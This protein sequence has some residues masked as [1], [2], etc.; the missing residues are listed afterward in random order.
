MVT[1]CQDPATR[2]R[3][4][5]Q[6]LRD[7][8][9]ETGDV[10][11]FDRKCL[12]M[13]LYGGAICLCAKFLGQTPWDHNGVVVRVPS[14]APHAT[15]PEDEL[16]LLEAALSGVKLRPLV[17]RIV[18]SRGHEVALRQLQLARTPAFQQKAVEFA[19][20]SLDT[21]YED[22][23]ATFF[24]A[25]VAVPTRSARER[26]FAALMATKK[27][28]VR[29]D[30]ELA[31][32]DRM[33]PFERNALRA[34]RD[35]VHAHYL[36]LGEKL[37]ARERSVFENAVDEGDGSSRKMFCSQLVAGL[38]QHLGLL[39]PYP[40]TNSYLP[41]HFSATGGAA[42]L[43][44]QQGASFLPAV[45]LRRKLE[46]ETDKAATRVHE[47]TARGPRSASERAVIVHC[48]RRHPLF[49]TLSES[50][51]LATASHFRRH[52]LRKGEVVF[53]QGAPGDY[54]YIVE[55]GQCEVYV[56][57]QESNQ[58]QTALQ[59]ADANE[60]MKHPARAPP[61]VLRKRQTVALPEFKSSSR[62]VG[63][64]ERVQV[65]TNG[66]GQAFGESA[67]IY[68][69]PRRA[70]IQASG[71]DAD[72]EDD[73][74]VLWQLEKR[75]FR[76]IVARHPG[77]Q[78]SMEERRFLLQTLEE[79]PLFAELDERAQAVAV[80]KCFPLH[81]RAGSTI[82]RQGDP[83]DYFYLV[84]SGRCQVSRRKP[85]ATKVFIDRIIG[86]GASFGEAALL[87]NSR[88]GASVKALDDVKIWCMDRA[89]F[90]TITRSGST[91]LYKLFRKIGSSV[92]AGSNESFATEKDLRR[93]L[94]APQLTRQSANKSD[95]DEED[96][97]LMTN[98]VPLAS[99]E[100][101]DRAVKLALSL[102]L[103][104]S[105]GLVN[106]SQFAHFHIALSASNIDQLLSEAAFRVLKSIA[107][108]YAEKERRKPRSLTS[109]F[110]FDQEDPDQ[111]AIK[112]Q[113]LPRALHQWMASKDTAGKAWNEQEPSV[114]MT[115]GR[116][117]LYEQLFDL[118]AHHFGD[119]YITH[120]DLVRG[121]ASLELDDKECGREQSDDDPNVL[122]AKEEFRAF[123]AALKSDLSALRSIWR[124]AELQA[125]VGDD[126]D[127]VEHEPEP[128]FVSIFKSSWIAA[129]RENP[130]GSDWGY[131]Q[132]KVQDQYQCLTP[133][134]ING[135]QQVTSQATS[136]VAA[137]AAGALM[138]TL[139]APLERLKMLMQVS[140][141]KPRV[142]SRPV[143]TTAPPYTS[144]TRGLVNMVKL[145]GTRSL[146]SG[147][148]VH[149]IEMIPLVSMR[150]LVCHVY[151]Q[152]RERLFP[153]SFDL[154]R[155]QN[156]QVA[157]RV[158]N[159]TV[160]AL[161]ALTLHC[162]LYPLDVIRGRLTVQQYYN[163]NR[164]LNGLVECAR[165][166]RAK[167]GVRAF[168][169]GFVPSSLG[170][171]TYTGCNVALYESLRPLFMLDDTKS[172]HTG[173]GQPTIRGQI[174]CS[175]VAALASQC[176]AYPFD[177]I[178]RR[179]QLQSTS[180]HPELEFPPSKSAWQ[181][182]KLSA[183]I[184]G[185][186]VRTM[187]LLYRGMFVNAIKAFPCTIISFLSYEKLCELE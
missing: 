114:E 17:A 81:V 118:P 35:A 26:L 180:W 143:G 154:I 80:R 90:L 91:A 76:D 136:L 134:R 123:L 56:E 157:A 158:T 42:F 156:P 89:S 184:E 149:C 181:W 160:G 34:E 84:E 8:R 12:S 109:P 79:H 72:E 129:V 37:R 103:N 161:V 98:T 152:Q 106:F 25:G 155:V 50:D 49:H 10:V 69:T 18:R 128:S 172:T 48:L 124:A 187:R 138:R 54:F 101:Y 65:A 125:H 39:L 176:L 120:D 31:H 99:E 186:G 112:L 4:V 73:A 171:C 9:V 122:A 175:T 145:G 75:A 166:I 87:Y 131:V 88:R 83:G 45:S 58:T 66:P 159:L 60:T 102:L 173:L 55:R 14:L 22:D 44:L 167:E 7:L 183:P 1:T 146:W 92:V 51:L 132:P 21:P 121:I 147:N 23:W 148:L 108:S 5:R 144:L 33:P 97:K 63:K 36:A 16:F 100:A 11:L 162:V 111:A 59:G 110:L 95:G 178:T 165:F 41:K 127:K 68:D 20:T 13:G 27:E 19:L 40:S 119:Q 142:S 32:R 15:A 24:N 133:S 168:Y 61:L 52:A 77:T 135:R 96:E 126:A 113:D 82:L 151:Q 130:I 164:P 153:A 115:P 141:P 86:R 174:M 185:S 28:L 137:I 139:C 116:L 179:V 64:H 30:L 105:T 70:T 38:Y 57:Y 2:E 53:Y 163:T 94:S 85:K 71:S 170:I 140:M 182:M 43:N 107:D 47:A 3:H 104:D 169:R 46:H 177:V 117:A 6:L 78:Q 74:V 93:M 67:L 62:L 150:F 29:L